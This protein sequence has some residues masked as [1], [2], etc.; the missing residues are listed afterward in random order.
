[1]KDI[2]D[3]SWNAAVTVNAKGS[4]GNHEIKAKDKALNLTGT[5]GSLTVKTG[6]A[7]DG[8]SLEAV[9]GG[10]LTVKINQIDVQSGLLNIAGAAGTTASAA[11]VEANT[12][13]VKGKDAKISLTAVTGAK[14]ATL[15]RAAAKGTNASTISLSNSGTISFNGGAASLAILQGELESTGGIL[16]VT[17]EKFGTISTFGTAEKLN[18]K[19][20]NSGS[21]TISLADDLESTTDKNE[22]TLNITSGTITL[23]AAAN[24]TTLT[25][26]KGTLNL[27]DSVVLQGAGTGAG[28]HEL[29]VG[30]TGAGELSLSKAT[31]TKFLGATTGVAEAKQ[32]VLDIAATGTVL[33]TDETVKLD[34]L[35]FAG[36]ATAGSI[37]FADGAKLGGNNV[38]VDD[39]LTDATNLTVLAKDTLTLGKADLATATTD[40]V[41]KFETKNLNLVT[42][43][44]SFTLQN[45]V[46]LKAI[47]DS[48][49]ASGDAIQVAQDGKID[50]KAINVSGGSITVGAGNYCCAKM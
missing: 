26:D 20:G 14:A 35:T 2:G 11:T 16:D 41:A 3:N 21:A 28:K 25:V 32:G 24:D 45:A 48:K 40:F 22:D 37:K 15:G 38:V 50:G 44:D 49:D 23:T 17:A 29:V 12:I 1:M 47:G 9:D 46:T 19:V 6:K 18:I 30:G 7:T 8:I 5:T 34:G 10:A 31:L 4:D 27:G 33:L 42:N 39:A 13:S 36:T 43:E